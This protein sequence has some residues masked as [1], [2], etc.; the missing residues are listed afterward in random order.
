MKAVL[1]SIRPQHCARIASRRK[2][3]ELRKR[4][5]KLPT[6]YKCYIYE[7]KG[8]TDTPWMDEDGHMDFRGRGQVIGE[9]ICDEVYDYEPCDYGIAA[10]Y[11]CVPFEDVVK[12]ADDGLTLHGLHISDLKIYDKPREISEFTRAGDCQCGPKA[13]SCPYMNKGDPEAGIEDDCSAP[14]DTTEHVPITR[15]PQ[16]WCYVE[17]REDIA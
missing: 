5:P 11:A 7:T 17:E 2:T 13:R 12:Y 3:I 6:P 1:L 14:F 15:A 4:V 8:P 9:F 16:S 10:T